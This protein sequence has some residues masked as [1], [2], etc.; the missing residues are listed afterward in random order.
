MNKFK[1][2][3]LFC[4]GAAQLLLKRCPTETSKYT[5]IGATVLFTGLFAALSSGYALYVIFDSVW[6]AAGFALVWGAM[7]FNFDRFIVSSIRK[8]KSFWK[9]FRIAIPR[10]VMAVILALVIS[11]PLELKIF[12]KEINRKL[13]DKRTSEA[14]KAKTAISQSFPEV[15]ELE[16]KIDLLKEEV[17]SKEA[18]RNKLQK[19]YDA[20]RF[21]KKTNETTGLAG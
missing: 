18:F 17:R 19:E 8:G 4:S 2:F 6:I 20:E 16:K 13:D 10:L 5:G 15:Q 9:E 3:F 21:G 1:Q 12:E 14:I 7:I 11:K